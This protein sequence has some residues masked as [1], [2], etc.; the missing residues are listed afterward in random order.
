MIQKVRRLDEYKI[1][2]KSFQSDS[3]EFE[4]KL[5]SSFFESLE[6]EEVNGGEVDVKLL[7][8][9]LATAFEFVFHTKG[10]V[11]V[12]CARCLDDIEVEVESEDVLIVKF[13]EEYSEEDSNLII[14]SEDEGEINVA[15]LMYEFIV[16]SL[17]SK[18]THPKGQCN[19]E[20]IKKLRE[21][22]AVSVDDEDED[23]DDT[24]YIDNSDE[25]REIDPRWNELKKILDNN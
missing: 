8:K 2:L 20:M 19:E 15:W 16:L 25:D 23:Y 22:L 18:T 10:A 12:P 11:S 21:H 13:G 5:D 14:I 24:E 9:K 1:S 17:P 7:V 3:L 4:Y 6:S